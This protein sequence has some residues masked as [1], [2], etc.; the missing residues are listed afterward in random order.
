MNKKTPIKS[1]QSKLTIYS[2]DSEIIVPPTIL[3]NAIPYQQYILW[4]STPKPF[5]K[6][7]TQKQLAVKLNIDKNTLSNWARYKETQQ[8]IIILT[9]RYLGNDIGTLMDICKKEALS[10]S[11][12]H[13]DIIMKFLN[14]IN[15]STIQADNITIQW[16]DK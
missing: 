12:K 14:L 8:N 16:Q 3:D 4:L 5:R 1:K 15:D 9:K 11:S 6:P 13:L 10:G 2:N 7:K